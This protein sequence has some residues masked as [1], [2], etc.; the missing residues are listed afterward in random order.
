M[1]ASAP[2]SRFRRSAVVAQLSV[3]LGTL[4]FALAG[5]ALSAAVVVL[6]LWRSAARR[7]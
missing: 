2:T 6:I 4:G 5:L 1:R 3:I 7:G